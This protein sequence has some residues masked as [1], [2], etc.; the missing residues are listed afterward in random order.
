MDPR[1][2][3]AVASERRR[4]ILR[5]VWDRELAAGDLARQFDVSWPAISQHLGVLK[6]A[7]LVRERRD[8]R[9]RLYSADVERAGP[10]AAVLEQMWR[11][12]LD[13]LAGL[14]EDEEA[15]GRPPSAADSRDAGEGATR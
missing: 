5:L 9:R 10:L 13:R 8:G 2:L 1:A 7:G 15:E 6:E 12:D 11:D 14:A 3:Q 4:R